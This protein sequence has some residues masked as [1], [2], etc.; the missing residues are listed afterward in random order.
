MKALADLLSLV[1]TTL[2]TW[3][4]CDTVQVLETHQFSN[5]Q[6][7][8]KVRVEMSSGGFLQIRLYRNGDHIDYAYQFV[9]DE[10]RVRWDNKEHFPSIPS[11]PH[12]FHNADGKI[13]ASS[14]TGN[15]AHDLPIVL[16]HLSTRSR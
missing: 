10:P 14:L 7:A 6:F 1:I 3:P 8:L 13:E 12:H 11:H 9:L 5:R 4:T 15:P 2:Q 16:D